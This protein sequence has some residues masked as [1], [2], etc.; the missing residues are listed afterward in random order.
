MM[1]SPTQQY[2]LHALKYATV[3]VVVMGLTIVA[4]GFLNNTDGSALTG[5]LVSQQARGVI[6]SVNFTPKDVIQGFSAPADTHIIVTLPPNVRIPRIALLGGPDYD[7]KRYWGY[8]YSGREQRNREAGKL[9]NDIYDGKFFYS[10]GERNAQAKRPKPSDTDLLG[11]YN[12]LHSA[13][14]EELES[15]AEILNGGD[16]FYL[17][18]NGEETSALPVALDPDGDLANNKREY[19]IGSDPNNFDTDGDGISDGKETFL[20]RTD[21]LRIDTDGDALNDDCEDLNQDGKQSLGETSAIDPDSDDDD[22]CDGNA[23]APHAE[24]CLVAVGTKTECTTPDSPGGRTC[25]PV[26]ASPIHSENPDLL[27]GEWHTR[28]IPQGRTN[29]TKF[30]TYPGKTDFQVLW[31]AMPR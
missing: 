18:V 30:E 20:T 5:R 2:A 23:L 25:R 12:D 31:E 3:T 1:S 29:P 4:V 13:A 27:C 8:V 28:Q 7:L 14:P 26:P 19:L 6:P 11:I 17:M 16:S 22:L 10:L 15:I 21:P 24:G 9:G